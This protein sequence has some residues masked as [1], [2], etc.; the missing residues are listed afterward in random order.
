[1]EDAKPNRSP[2]MGKLVVQFTGT[3]SL[4]GR[5][6]TVIESFVDEKGNTHCLAERQDGSTFWC[7]ER[8]LQV[9]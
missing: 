5:R 2:L 1:M 8:F 3:P 9:L 6:G 7:P 4:M